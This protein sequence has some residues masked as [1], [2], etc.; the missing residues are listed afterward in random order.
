MFKLYSWKRTS[1]S[2]FAVAAASLGTIPF[3][4]TTALAQKVVDVSPAQN[5]Q[6]VAADTSITGLFDTSDGSQVDLS[7]VKIFLN[8]QDVTTNSTITGNFFSYRP[9]QPL[10]AGNNQ[11][12]LEFN[13]VSG[14]SWVVSWNFAV[15]QPKPALEISSVTHNGG[16]EP[17]GSDAT[18]LVTINGTPGSQGNVTLVEDGKVVRQFNTQEVSQGVYVATVTVGTNAV[19]EGIVVGRLQRQEQVTYSAANQSVAFSPNVTTQQVTQVEENPTTEP[20]PV[21]VESTPEPLT[22]NLTSHQE[23]E[24]I[25]TQG[26]TLVGE[27]LPEATVNVKVTSTVQALGGFVSIGGNTLLTEQAISADSNGRFQVEIPRPSVVTSGTRYTVE[28]T[29]SKDEQT[30]S[31]SLNLTQK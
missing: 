23:G 10:S 27:T 17:L 26:F 5:S 22:V 11:V 7:T 9:T 13:N 6:D 18:L 12:K 19:T 8:D 25:S 30:S 3:L 31:T 14:Q 2:I 16:S 21:A 20:T 4:A 15:E 28:V 29:A 24:A 1:L